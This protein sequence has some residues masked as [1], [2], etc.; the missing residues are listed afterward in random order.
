M[1]E[2]YKKNGE[3]KCK[4]NQREGLLV[5]TGKRF[6]GALFCA[7][8]YEVTKTPLHPIMCQCKKAY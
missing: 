3:R 6:N 4:L 5:T 1:K 7:T 2:K 8:R